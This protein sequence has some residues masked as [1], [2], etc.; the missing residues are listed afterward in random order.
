MATSDC[1]D[2]C[3]PEVYEKCDKDSMSEKVNIYSGLSG[4][5]S[6]I[7]KKVQSALVDGIQSEISR[8][9]ND[10]IF[11]ILQDISENYG[12]PLVEL[13]ERYDIS[14]DTLS[15]SNNSGSGGGNGDK[16]LNTEKKKR[17]RKKKQKDEFIETY[18]HEY[19]GETYL[20]DGNNNVYTYNLEEPM[21]IGEMLVDGTI[22]K[23]D[24][25]V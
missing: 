7:K 19:E 6:I 15:S 4:C 17:G 10:T 3:L 25:E 14:A 2:I 9:M 24:I 13:Q 20:V 12:I 5:T 18:K 11:N 21:L 16:G 22:K 23:Y 8:Y 1:E